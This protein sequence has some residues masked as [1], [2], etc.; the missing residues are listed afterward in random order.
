MTLDDYAKKHGLTVE[1][2]SSGGKF[3]LALP[4]APDKWDLFHLSDYAVGAVAGPVY[5]LRKRE[6]QESLLTTTI[7]PTVKG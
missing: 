5:W 7:N 1:T 6:A 2:H 4:D 3:F